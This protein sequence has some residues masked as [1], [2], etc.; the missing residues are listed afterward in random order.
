M[1]CSVQNPHED[2]QRKTDINDVILP[3]YKNKT[4]TALLICLDGFLN[5]EIFQITGSGKRDGKSIARN[6]NAFSNT[7]LYGLHYL[8]IWILY[9]FYMIFLCGR[10]IFIP[11]LQMG[12]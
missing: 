7:Y 1:Y 5:T 10:K 6:K 8:G 11:I 4:S 3:T 12:N 9:I 2:S